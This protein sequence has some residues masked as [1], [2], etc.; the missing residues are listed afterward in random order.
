MKKLSFSAVFALAASCSFGTLGF[1]PCA[2]AQYTG[3]MGMQFNNM[4]SATI[5]TMVRGMSNMAMLRASLRRSYIRSGPTA[6][7]LQ[8]ARGQRILRAG[9]ASVT[10]PTR[11]WFTPYW[12]AHT[13]IDGS[14]PAAQYRQIRASGMEK[15]QA[16][17]NR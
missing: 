1:A 16:E 14:I 9:R 6:D 13:K 8:M 12:M 10:F 7:D 11:P 4:Q 2:H 5:S 3:A 15:Q 17:F